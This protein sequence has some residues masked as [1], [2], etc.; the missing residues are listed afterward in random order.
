M[1]SKQT[2]RRRFLKNGVALAGV[3]VGAMQ[4]SN[5]QAP[6]PE[7]PAD[8]R[9]DFR[10]YGEPS[11]F[12]T[13][14]RTS[15]SANSLPHVHGWVSPLQDLV[16]TITPSGLHFWEDHGYVLPVED[17]DP[18]Q[19]RLMIHGLVDRPRMY[20]MEELRR[21]P[22]A[23]RI[24][25]LECNANSR[26]LS[27]PNG[28]LLQ[29]VH[30]KAS[31]SEWTGVLLS[32]L[33]RESGL[34]KG[35]SWLVVE[36]ADTA[37]YTTSIPIEKAMEDVLVAYGQNGE[38]VRPEQGYPLRLVVPGYYGTYWVKHLNEISVTS[39]VFNGYWM[40]PAYRVPDNAC[41]CVPAGTAPKT[42]VPIARCNVRSFITSV[43]EGDTIALARPKTIKGIAF[44]GGYGITEVL[45][46][47]DGGRSWQ[48]AD[49]GKDLGQYSFREW[50]ATF[51]PDRAGLLELKAKA[52]NRIGQSQ[53]LEAL[54]NPAGYMRNTVETVHV[55]AS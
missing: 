43:T 53:P 2:G 49:L 50:T 17:M 41:A 21:L 27:G 20:T 11:H 24:H 19:Y 45:F 38:D 31:C 14:A 26:P 25:F 16:G 47:A 34:Q 28:G 36:G 46:S 4:N 22:S 5:S 10:T 37:K 48:R 12:A 52:T 54:W 30:G 51:V 23:S 13:S 6:A 1:S 55:K 40:N 42:T 9:K 29:Q 35:G 18:R 32:L 44:D 15:Y 8:R 33:L 3:A 39:E 7:T